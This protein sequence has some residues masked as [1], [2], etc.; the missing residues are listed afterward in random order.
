[1]RVILCEDVKKQK[2]NAGSKARLDTI[3]IA[4]KNGYKHI[5]LYHNNMPKMVKV[6]EALWNCLRIFLIVREKE[7]IL[8]QYPYPSIF[9]RFFFSLLR[10]GK[11]MKGYTVVVLIHDLI[12]LRNHVYATK[13][14]DCNI[15]LKA[16]LKMMRKFR[17]IYHNDKM[18]DICES[19]LA[20][21]SYR[22]LGP[23]DYLYSGNICERTFLKNP[24]VM[25][26]GN[27][28][29]QKSKYIYHLSDICDVR[30]D[31]FGTNYEGLESNNVYYRGVFDPKEL[32]MHMDGQFGLV[33]DGDS[34]ETCSGLC[35]QYLRY[36]N[37]HKLSLYIAAGVPLIIWE[38][39]AL[40][41]YVQQNNIGFCVKNLYDLQIIV[42]RM[43]EEEYLIMVLNV[44][45]LRKTIIA[46]ENLKRCIGET[47][48]I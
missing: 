21:S 46:G 1:M 43:T 33:W 23:F 15:A 13:E 29:K 48:N 5:E 4:I 2:Y 7:I 32:I 28:S 12:S 10:I 24:V 3:E 42:K 19:V 8:V 20:A 39:S 18:R 35:G 37:P 38:E 14:K 47:Y 11:K 40:A 36:N 22:V 16:E 9:N 25:I 41:D 44:L 26:A 45:R 30:F 6:L 34:I 27:L 31:L 17:I